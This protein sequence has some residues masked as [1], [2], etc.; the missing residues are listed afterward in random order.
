MN[1]GRVPLMD[2][3]DQRFVA[4]VVESRGRTTL[5]ADD[6]R[7]DGDKPDGDESRH[8]FLELSLSTFCTLNEKDPQG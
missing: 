6:E 4:T 7:H 3:A 2:G 8:R 1:D 5:T